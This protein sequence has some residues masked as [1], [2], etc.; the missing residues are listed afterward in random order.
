MAEGVSENSFIR[1]CASS[2]VEAKDTNASRKA[3]ITADQQLEEI[4]QRA[5]VLGKELS[6]IK[7]KIDELTK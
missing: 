5:E 4:K 3:T 2:R 7:N 6:D 1:S